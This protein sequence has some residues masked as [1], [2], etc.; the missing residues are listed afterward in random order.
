MGCL[1]D[2]ID[3][4]KVIIKSVHKKAINVT[5]LRQVMS[6][7]IQRAIMKQQNGCGNRRIEIEQTVTSIQFIS[8]L[9]SR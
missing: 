3:S 2:F 8:M 4:R 9:K 5:P 1:R 6:K 7:S